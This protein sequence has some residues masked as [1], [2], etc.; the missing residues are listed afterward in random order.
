M[1]VDNSIN[2]LLVVVSC[3]VTRT[4]VLEG[5]FSNVD[6]MWK[7]Q[8]VAICV[9]HRRGCSANVRALVI[10]TN[11]G[12]RWKCANAMH[13]YSTECPNSVMFDVGIELGDGRSE[14]CV[15][16]HPL[17]N[18]LICIHHGGMV[19]ST[20]VSTDFLEGVA[21]QRSR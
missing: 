8:T 5:R 19:A 2:G 10:K 13:M 12:V 20:E 11:D 14:F 6:N 9:M 15:T 18:F 7:T 3:C 4:C 1:A 21:R 17:P 16:L